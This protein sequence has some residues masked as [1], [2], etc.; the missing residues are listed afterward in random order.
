MILAYLRVST[1][2]QARSGLGLDAQRD[3]IESRLGAPARVFID[4]GYSGSDAKRSALLEALEALSE[5]DV[6][7]VAKRD[8]LARDV[9]LSAWI[10]KEAKRRGARVA[11][12]AGE[13]TDSDDPA[14]VLMRTIVDAFAEY[15]RNL[16]KARTAAA[17]AQKRKRGEKT[18]GDVP[19]GYRLAAD[20]VHLEADPDEQAVVEL[21]RQ[22]Q[23]EGESLRQIGAELERRGVLTRRGK[24]RWHPQ[25]IKQV[26]A[27]KTEFGKAA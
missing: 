5:G 9:Y 4:D 17:L 16:I 13:G 10:E 2:E 12:A 24:G 22:L 6:L 11:S 20:G 8:R 26:L 1:E 7:A 15:E 19:F 14:S 25:V 23:E 27:Q 3:A 21:I 18:G